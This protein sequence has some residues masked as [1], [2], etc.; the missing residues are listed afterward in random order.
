MNLDELAD[1]VT[2][3]EPP[4]PGPR[5]YRAPVPKGFEPG[6][7]YDDAGQP[8]EITTELVAE[9]PTEDEWRHV[10][11]GMG[12]TMPTGWRLVL[13][14]ARFDPV[15]WTRE[16]EFT[17]HP[18]IDKIVRTP[19]TTR[20]A[21]RYRF[22]VERV[23]DALDLA[24]ID[25]T[26]RKW[27]PAKPTTVTGGDVFTVVAADMQIGKVEP[28]IGGTD[29][30]VR[31][32]VAL[33]A[34]AVTEYKALARR[35]IVG[36]AAIILPGDGCEGFVSQGGRLAWRTD[37][38]ATRMRTVY[39]RLIAH[40]VLEFARV[41]PQ[42]YVVTVGGNHDQAVRQFATT[43][44][45]SWDVQ[46]AIDLR[47]HMALLAPEKFAH[48]HW[49]LP[50]TDSD[51]VAVDLAGT[52]VAVAHGHQFKGGAEKWWAGQSHGLRDAGEAALLISGHYHHLKVVTTGGGR[53]WIQ[54]PALD[55]GSEW[56]SR[57]TGESSAA[58]LLT[59]T[60]GRGGWDRLRVLTWAEDMPCVSS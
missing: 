43:H 14:E 27:R 13:I 40:L 9:A 59:L 31:R 52:V 3:D 11:E 19:A 33:T 2:A 53:T 49:H 29:R 16:T 32:V 4:T 37:L 35:G 8:A 41:A 30:T 22:R 46:A 15:A 34:Q 23:A 12:I 38:N 47:D 58:G 6:I 51:V 57:E 1:R 10:V 21:W 42:V 56:F 17:P 50:S 54:A 25:D 44:D 5:R 39:G 24:W 45:D 26:I 20:P 36:P 48:V 60:V 28:G 7:R 55:N 18:G